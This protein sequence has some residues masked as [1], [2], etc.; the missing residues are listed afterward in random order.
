MRRVVLESPY[1]GNVRK[2]RAYARACVKDCLKRGEAPIAS[3]LLFTQPGILSDIDPEERRL[4]MAAG[5]AW[6]P[7]A[8]AVVVYEDL[9]ISSGMRAGMEQAKTAGILVEHR[10][11][12]QVPN[13]R[14]K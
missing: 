1:S 3:H 9:G 11:L 10:R 12:K 2:N 6:I 8:D 7:I 13:G 4:G 5:W 14:G